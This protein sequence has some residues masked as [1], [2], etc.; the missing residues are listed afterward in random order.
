M[1]NELKNKGFS[2]TEVLMSV[3]ILAVGML[4]IA[5]VFPVGI[6]F[7]TVSTERTTAAV[8]A[9]EAFAKIRLYNLSLMNSALWEPTTK[10]IPGYPVFCVDIND[11][12]SLGLV[13]AWNQRLQRVYKY[14]YYYPSVNVSLGT[15]HTYTWTALCRRLGPSQTRDVQVTV[16]VCRIAGPHRVYQRRYSPFDV[17]VAPADRNRLV[18]AG[19]IRY[20]RLHPVPVFINVLLPDIRRRN[21]LLIDLSA[22]YSIDIENIENT[23]IGEGYTIVDDETGRI[24]RVLKRYTED[25]DSP[26]LEDQLIQLDR[27]F[28]PG[29]W[30]IANGRGKVWVIPPAF[31]GGRNPCVG[32]YQKVIRF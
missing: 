22:D 16:F 6:H 17:F 19:D 11:V 18:Q 1:N 23:F 26:I 7:S 25:P 31:G 24:Y 21:E 20:P 10:D 12:S 5:G 3:G 15:K 32:V 14:E 13:R 8:V 30:F 29:R 4:F 28:V 9:D 2:L 27:N